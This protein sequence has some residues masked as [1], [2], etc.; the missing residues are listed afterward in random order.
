MQQIFV[1]ACSSQKGTK[2]GERRQLGR[3][4][5][6]APTYFKLRT[7]TQRRTQIYQRDIRDKQCLEA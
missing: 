3:S 1:F 4:L 5:I 2:H 7:L 6:D